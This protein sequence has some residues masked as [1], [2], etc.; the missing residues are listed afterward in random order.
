MRIRRWAAV[1]ALVAAA[2]VHTQPAEAPDTIDVVGTTPL[3]GSLAAA[4]VAANVQT[5]T[6]EQIR[7]QGALDLADFMRRSLGSVFVNDSQG[8]PLEPDVQYRGF[9]GSPLLGLPQGIAIYQDGVRINDPF[10]DTANWALIPKSAIDTV[11]LMPGSNP[12]FGLNALGGAISIRT[13]DGFE[14][15]GTRGEAQAGSFGRKSVQAETGGATPGGLGYFVTASRFDEDGWRD[16]SPSAATQV[17]ASL[18]SSI[19]GGHIG[20]TFTHADTDLIGNGPAPVDLLAVDRS[21]V[22]TRPDRVRSHSNLLNITADQH[23]G[24]GP[25]LSGNLYVRDNRTDTLNGDNSDYVPC[26]GT[27]GLL[28]AEDGG[29]ESVLLDAAGNPIAATPSVDSAILN[30]TRT[31]Q[32]TT[33]FA[34]QLT[35]TKDGHRGVTDFLLGIARDS[36]NA[37]FTASAELGRLDATRLAVPGGV[38]VGDAFTDLGARITNTAWYVSG[39]VALGAKTTLTLSGRYNRTAVALEDRLGDALTG[40][41]AFSRFNPAVG[42]IVALGE[43][44]SFYSSYS[45]ANRAPSPVELTCANEA[46]PCR[47]PNAFVADPPLE[48]VVAS[49]F[50]TGFRGRWDRGQWHAGVFRTTNRHDILFIS[51]GALTNEGFFANVGGTRRQGIELEADGAFGRVTWFANLTHL[52]ATFREAFSVSSPHNP[53]AVGGEIAVQVGDR[54][55]LIPDRLLKIGL[56]S[57]IGSK[58]TIGGDLL[59]SAGQYLRGDEANVAGRTDVYT[60]LDLRAEYRLGTATHVFVNVDNALDKRYETFG[61]FGQPG[62]VLGAALGNPRFVGPGAPRGIWAGVRVAFR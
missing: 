17:F 49:T 55:P 62:D 25:S 27:P 7:Q 46:D 3:G 30:R 10:G 56:R 23:L 24:T 59:T 48:Q 47:L 13:K 16:F 20:A 12:L 38:F 18:I 5:A 60:L 35:W 32:E 34:L 21:A 54:L 40:A 36:S 4:R 2:E 14:N 22:F 53:A 39:N 6:A 37:A 29:G 9:V 15:P 52:D 43:S 28:C 51:A 41:H 57:A 8:N 31:A 33:G 42:V 50:E 1:A 26:S 44:L 58:W 11:Q 61:L 45:Q 19:D